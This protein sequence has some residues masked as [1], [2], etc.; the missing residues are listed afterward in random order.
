MVVKLDTHQLRFSN[1]LIISQKLS[2]VQVMHKLENEAER[3][4]GCGIQ[5]NQRHEAPVVV[6]VEIVVCQRFFI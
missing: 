2:Q 1:A 6:I 4:L 5:S 3:V